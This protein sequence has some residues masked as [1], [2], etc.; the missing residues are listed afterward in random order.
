M[1]ECIVVKKILKNK[2]LEN[3]NYDISILPIKLH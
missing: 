1:E 2:C 3:F